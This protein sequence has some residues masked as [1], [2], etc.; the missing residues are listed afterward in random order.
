MSFQAMAWAIKQIAPTKPKF[1]LL[2]LANYAD[3]RGLAWPSLPV[4][5]KDTGIKRSTLIECIKK[6]VELGLIEK[7]KRYKRNL[8]VSNMYRLKVP[9]SP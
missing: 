4:L 7:V 9:E 2:V 3:D 6:L 5:T 1:V 8:K